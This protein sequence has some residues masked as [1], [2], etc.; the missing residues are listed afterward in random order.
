MLGVP[1]RGAQMADRMKQVLLYRAIL[2]PAGQQL[3]SDPEGFIAKL[4]TP[5]FEFAVLAGGR[6]NTTGFNPLV[7][8]D[9][10]GTVSVASTRLP[11][12]ADF[13]VVECLHSFLVRHA[14]AIDYT[15]RFLKTGRLREKGDPHPIPRPRRSCDRIEQN[16]VRP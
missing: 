16:D 4:P 3:V 9:D 6:R 13:A 1:N 15:A 10:D 8:G 14:G 12:A 11:G 5:D 2:G 7:P